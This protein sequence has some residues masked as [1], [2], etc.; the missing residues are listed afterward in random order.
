MRLLLHVASQCWRKRAAKSV[1]RRLFLPCVSFGALP[2]VAKLENKFPFDP[3]D[4][5]LLFRFS[6]F[7][8]S[9]CSYCG[10][11]F[12]PPNRLHIKSHFS[13]LKPESILSSKAHFSH[14]ATGWIYKIFNSIFT[15]QPHLMPLLQFDARTVGYR[16]V[17][18]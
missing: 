7:S 18:R 13:N 3:S 9:F 17:R 8:F 12:I 10:K 5:Y 4:V 16:W 15:S 6:F 14:V 2:L 11:Y 1:G